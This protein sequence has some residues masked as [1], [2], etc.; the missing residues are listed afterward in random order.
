[1]RYYML[2]LITALAALAAGQI[3]AEGENLPGL[4]LVRMPEKAPEG[5]IQFSNVGAGAF[6]PAI[7][8]A[9]TLNL[10]YDQQSPL[11][12]P[13]PGDFRNIYAPSAVQLPG[14]AGWRVFYGAWDGTAD[15]HDRIYSVTT[16]DFRTFA[17]RHTVI[18]HGP[19]HHV[20]NVNAIP[21][22]DASLMMVCTAYPDSRGLNKPVIFRSPDGRVWNG[23]AAPY[24]ASTDDFI[25]MEGYDGFTGADINGMNVLLFD[26]GVYRLYF[27]DFKNFKGVYRASSKDGRHFT[28]DGV[29]LERSLAV[30]DVKKFRVGQ[31]SHYLMGLHMNGDTLWYSLSSNG[32][33]FQPVQTLAKNLG[34]E[35]RYIVAHG[36]VVEGDQELEGRRLLGFL[37][38][39]GSHN[40]LTMNRIFARWLQKKVELVME[41]GSVLSASSAHGPNAQLISLP[42]GNSIQATIRVYAEDGKTLITENG[43]FNLQSG[44][45]YRLSW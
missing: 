35:D 36:W 37:Y 1:M 14:K 5:T 33:D 38:G 41:D 12:E 45:T 32:Q 31:G 44:K 27:G 21:L 2:V 10:L 42:E 20:C 28:F 9:G 17:N 25:L 7:W 43:P 39:A 26:N 24:T 16:R 23:T 11:L 8:Q 13:L 34:A 3:C 15:G 18:E 6:D 22:P 40:S 19:F 4:K 30:N 29:S